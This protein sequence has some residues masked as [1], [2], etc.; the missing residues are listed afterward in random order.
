VKGNRYLVIGMLSLTLIALEL[1]W[2]RIFSAEYFYTF[3]FLVLSLAVLGIGLGALALRLV[4][5]LNDDRYLGPA[6]SLTGLMAL[7]GPPLV[8]LLDLKL[9]LLFTSWKMVGLFAAT[10]LILNS[11]F[12][13]GG[14]ALALLFRRHHADMPRMYMADLLGA[15]AGVVVA[16]VA[17]NL[18]GTPR[19]ALWVA[20]PALLAS[21]IAARGGWRALPVLLIAVTVLLGAHAD[22]VM[23]SHARDRAP[24]GYLHWDASARIKIYEFNEFYHGIEIDNAANSPVF[25]FDGN[26]DRPDSMRFGFDIDVG[27]L[28]G[29]FDDCSFLSLGAGGG[30]DVL[31]ALQ[32]GATDIH[33]VEVVPHIN[34]LMTEGKLAEFSGGIY[35]DPRVTV[36]TEDARAYVRRHP[37]RFDVI[38]S[39][40]SNTFAALASGA[41]ALS[42]NYL[43][44]TEAF[45][46]YWRSLSDGGF[47]MMEH[48][49]YAPRM[50]SEVLDAL[51][52]EGVAD[53]A[54]HLAV[55]DMPQHRRNII[56][57]SKRALDDE[58]RI[59]ALAGGEEALPEHI[60]PLYPAP[61]DTATT[62][63]ARIVEEGW[64]AVQPD[65]PT[66]LSPCDDD[67][68]FVAQL[69]LWR[70]ASREGLVNLSPLEIR[71]FPVSRV[72]VLIILAV[73]LVIVVPLNLL[74]ALTHGPR[75]RAAPWLYFFLLGA[76]YMA[77]EVVLIQKYTLFVGPSVYSISTILLTLLVASGLGSRIAD[78][79]PDGRPFLGILV[80]IALD[81]LVLP[82]LTAT[83]GG[84]TMAPRMIVAAALVFPLGFCM[85]MPFPKGA[86]RVGELV[87]WGF[88][89]NGAAS[90]LG[91]T[92]IILVAFS[93]GYA[94]ALSTAGALYLS[95]WLLLARRSAWA[96]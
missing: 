57:L 21:L 88:A 18:L 46:D 56:L 86:L 12:F 77:V 34:W 89:V 48:Q 14:V 69:G 93:W 78:R 74:P 11:A 82:K 59:A 3:A 39:L 2:T 49:F 1:T 20:L 27:G 68:P 63:A 5:A 94:A 54:A 4:P 81:I 8:L 31:Q 7:A 24:V 29:M 35:N 38:Y 64:R 51:R 26:W 23:Q 25:A 71:G 52:A 58:L 44:T 42:E 37:G 55:Y 67:R 17:M 91:S 66:D 43:F 95:A 87:D 62:L 40:S 30:G 73:V 47:L 22:L 45:R 65:H 75:L 96:R 72:M 16:I 19:A 79:V 76:A 60:V 90:V 80:W 41:F 10:V 6:L 83:M 28:I 9:G 33:A 36:A 61:S 13:F 70:N 15:G 84:M 53:P 85:G 50:I 32:A 92:A